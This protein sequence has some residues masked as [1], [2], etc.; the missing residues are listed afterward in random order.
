[1]PKIPNV[2]WKIKGLK[3][4]CLPDSFVT[5]ENL[6]FDGLDELEELYRF[7]SKTCE[8]TDLWEL[9]NLRRLSASI[10]GNDNLSKFIDSIEANVKCLDYTLV[11]L[12]DCDFRS[13][14]GM[15]LL[16]QVFKSSKIHSLCLTREVVHLTKL[17]EYE[18]C[19][20]PNLGELYLYGGEI[21]ED[22]MGTLEKLSNLRKLEIS[23]S[24][25]GEEMI[26]HDNGFPQLRHL[27]LSW[28]SNLKKWTVEE[29]AMPSLSYLL[30]SYCDHL[31][32][33]PGGIKFITTLQTLNI[34]GMPEAFIKR[35]EEGGEDFDKV[36][37]VNSII[38]ISDL[39]W[40]R[41]IMDY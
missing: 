12:R 19:F 29:G 7:N 24:F 4:L 23:E 11:L 22:P 36:C 32:M 6:E 26:C 17:P 28:L 1:M 35:V 8:I 38:K 10:Y 25:V 14:E 40:I 20:F 34:G 15:A 5:E 41:I 27:E 3:Y 21:S 37:H 13:E 9:R 2:L 16:K 18:P 39:D 31:D 33:V 30:V